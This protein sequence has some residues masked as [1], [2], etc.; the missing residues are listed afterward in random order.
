MRWRPFFAAAFER[1]TNLWKLQKAQRAALVERGGLKRHHIGELASR[2]G[3]LY[4]HYYLRNSDPVYLRQAAAFYASIHDRD[5]F[6]LTS[7]RP[8]LP[9]D[10]DHEEDG[11]ELGGRDTEDASHSS[12]NGSDRDNDDNHDPTTPRE[13]PR[14]AAV[15]EPETATATARNEDDRHHAGRSRPRATQGH[16]DPT[17]DAAEAQSRRLRQARRQSHRRRSARGRRVAQLAER[18]AAVDGTRAMRYFA[19]FLVVRLLLQEPRRAVDLLLAA[20]QSLLARRA[21]GDRRLRQAQREWEATCR[22]GSAFVRAA[23]TLQIVV[24]ATGAPPSL[25]TQSALRTPGALLPPD[26]VPPVLR[27]P[28]NE[29]RGTRRDSGLRLGEAILVGGGLRQVH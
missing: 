9:L 13:V 12:G 17:G 27:L 7:A 22:E 14:G 20:M 2:V 10:D 18:S 11:D 25:A 15:G 26:F 19:R 5:Y 21:A 24:P 23:Y 29:G 3:Q 4:Y 28:L 8:Q 1:Y 16:V 6:D